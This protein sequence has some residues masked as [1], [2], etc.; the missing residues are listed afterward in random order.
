MSNFITLYWDEKIKR[1]LWR[2]SGTYHIIN[3]LLYFTFLTQTVKT[4]HLLP[5]FK[6]YLY[7]CCTKQTCE[8]TP[9]Y[10][11][12]EK[13]T[14]TLDKSSFSGSLTQNTVNCP[15]PW[16]RFDLLNLDY[17]SLYYFPL[18]IS[19]HFLK[20]LYKGAFFFFFCSISINSTS[21][22]CGAYP[23]KDRFLDSCVRWDTLTIKV[24]CVSQPDARI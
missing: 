15:Y 23:L 17:D 8:A 1:V 4:P 20:L 22:S 13:C 3:L 14:C 11:N 7:L 10:V 6:L 19:S 9:F 21:N 5:T 18:V 2:I 16:L 24:S 12:K